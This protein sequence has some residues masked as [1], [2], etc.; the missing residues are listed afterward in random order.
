MYRFLISTAAGPI[1][2]F[3][4]NAG[5]PTPSVDDYVI[6]AT[7]SPGA[8]TKFVLQLLA[9]KTTAASMD[10]W[11]IRP[12]YENTPTDITATT[13]AAWATAVPVTTAWPTQNF[14]TV[15]DCYG[16]LAAGTGTLASEQ[17]DRLM[18]VGEKEGAG[19]I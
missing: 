13:T 9:D 16:F 4:L 1:T 7:A 14:G 2:D 12:G 19:Y 3:Y 8:Y 5:T 11:G 10:A 15:I 17:V 6:T 18:C